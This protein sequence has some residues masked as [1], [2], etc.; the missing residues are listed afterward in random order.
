MSFLEELK[1]RKVI[2]VAVGYLAAAW[3]ILQVADVILGNLSAP[4]WVFQGVLLLI[5]LG[6]PVALALAWAFEV[7]PEAAGDNAVRPRRRRVDALILLIVIAAAGLF[8]FNWFLD[9]VVTQTGQEAGVDSQAGVRS[10]AAPPT[11]IAVLAFEN[12]STDPEQE[13][14]AEGLAEEILVL[15]ANIPEFDVISR[16][17]S[18]SFKGSNQDIRTI[19]RELGVGSIVEGSV[20]KSGDRVRIRVQLSNV[21]DGRSVWSPAPFEEELM[22]TFAIQER[23]AADIVS[24]L[25]VEIGSLPSRGR[26]T[27]NADAYSNFL[28]ARVALDAQQG[29]TAV[30]LLKEAVEFDPQFAEAWEYLAFAY[31]Q[32]S[33]TSIEVSEAQSLSHEAAARALEIFPALVFAQALHALSDDALGDDG[34]AVELL[35]S[36]TRQQPANSAPM[37]TLLYELGFRGYL[38]E[39]HRMATRFVERDPLSPVAHYSLGESLVAVGRSR[40]AIAPLTRAFDLDNAFAQWFL[41]A[42]HLLR[43]EDEVAAAIYDQQLRTAGGD[44]TTSVLEIIKGARKPD[45]GSDLLDKELPG[46]IEALPDEAAFDWIWNNRVWHLVLGHLDEYYDLIDAAG[47]RAGRWTDADVLIWLGT[48]FRETGFTVHPRFIEMS[49]RVGT[50]ALWDVRGAPDFCRKDDNAWRCN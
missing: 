8:A 25:Q 40:E 15:L 4:G 50:P 27:D 10:I 42:V 48:V 5:I 22:D 45:G 49:E 6:F 35:V 38:A 33:G 41:P 16:T 24:A 30:R 47:P 1:R 19:G 28:K 43:G 44:G 32:Q 26:P 21:A 37:R 18:F 46:L 7:R 39:A 3:L 2:R 20:Q 9:D 11:S 29:A 13:F 34:R 14:L 12:R 17:S 23:I 36:A 31:W